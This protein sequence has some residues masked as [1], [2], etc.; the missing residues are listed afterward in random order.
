MCPFQ[1]HVRPMP[2]LLAPRPIQDT[3]SDV[4]LL[5]IISFNASLHS[6]RIFLEIFKNFCCCALTRCCDLSIYLERLSITKIS[7]EDQ[8]QRITYTPMLITSDKILLVFAFYLQPNLC[9]F[10]VFPLHFSS[11]RLSTLLFH[12]PHN[13]LIPHFLKCANFANCA[14][15]RLRIRRF[16]YILK[17]AF[18]RSR[19]SRA[20]IESATVVVF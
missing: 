4:K 20:G 11:T 15:K 5:I 18:S 14:K 9:F 6:L 7:E 17:F 12:D 16:G 1:C 8:R 13:S 2:L 19:Y 10:R 3:R